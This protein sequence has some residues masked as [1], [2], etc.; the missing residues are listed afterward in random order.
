MQIY[1]SFHYF[2]FKTMIGNSYRSL[3]CHHV[4][5]RHGLWRIQL[6]SALCFT[7]FLVS[8]LGSH[9]DVATDGPLHLAE[10]TFLLSY[11]GYIAEVIF[12]H[13]IVL[14]LPLG[15]EPVWYLS[16][17][18]YHSIEHKAWSASETLGAHSRL[19]ISQTYYLISHHLFM[20]LCALT[21]LSDRLDSLLG[22]ITTL[23]WW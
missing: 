15:P 16:S 4:R 22:L 7:S 9:W 18:H 14:S 10:V 11:S 17:Y 3:M 21:L 19:S 6:L 23:R 8:L 2:P 20:F 5:I 13:F 12:L 1:L